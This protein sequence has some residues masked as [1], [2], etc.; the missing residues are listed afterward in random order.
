[1]LE[2]DKVVEI[3]FKLQDSQTGLQN[4][5]MSQGK[6]VTLYIQLVVPVL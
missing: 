3:Q 4:V 2:G 5:Y 6:K 1:M